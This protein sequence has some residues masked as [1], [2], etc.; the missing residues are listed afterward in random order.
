MTTLI[1]F[2]IAMICILIINLLNGGFQAREFPAYII[3]VIL[4]GT[5]VYFSTRKKVLWGIVIPIFIALTFYP[6]YRIIN[7]TGT[8]VI[9]LVGLY[10]IAFSLS[11][12]IWY[13]ARKNDK[14]DE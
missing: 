7:P 2:T 10:V 11:L 8:E 12:I 14:N 4:L 9:M 1:C 5:H 13:Q 3:M 6:V